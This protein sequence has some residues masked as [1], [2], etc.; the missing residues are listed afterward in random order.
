MFEAMEHGELTR[1]LRDRR[2]PGAVRGR[3]RARRRAARR[4]RPPGRAGHLPHQ[5]RAAG[6]R[7][8]AGHG[9]VVR[10]RGHGHQQRAP[11]AAGAQG[12]SSRPRAPATTSRSSSTSPRRLGPRLDATGVVRGGVGRAA[13]ALADARRHDLPP[14]RGA[15]RHPVAVLRPRTGSSRP[16][17]TAGCGPTTR[18]SGAGRRRSRVV[19]DDPPVDAARRRVP[20]AAHDRPPA[21]LLQHRRAVGRLRL[22]AALRRDDRPVAGGRGAPRHRPTASRSG[23]RPGAARWS[24]RSASTPRCG[25]A[26][27]S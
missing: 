9:G 6:R 5:D 7:R 27:C 24:R 3:E 23:S 25:P 11:G 12:R 13:L 14:P 22:A 18:P 20:A 1:A 21:R 16:T 8:A 26:W 2:E 19:V 15:R 4:P 10:D 17:C